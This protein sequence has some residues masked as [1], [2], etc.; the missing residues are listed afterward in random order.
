M[1]WYP[2]SGIAMSHWTFPYKSLMF[3]WIY[4]C[5]ANYSAAMVYGPW[6]E[7]FNC[8]HMATSTCIRHARHHW[9]GWL[10]WMF[11]RVEN[12]P[13]CLHCKHLSKNV[14]V[15]SIRVLYSIWVIHLQQGQSSVTILSWFK[16]GCSGR[17]VSNSL[18]GHHERLVWSSLEYVEW[19]EE[20]QAGKLGHFPSGERKAS[21]SLVPDA[22]AARGRAEPIVVLQ[23]TDLISRG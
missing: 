20:N 10:S 22:W 21:W 2:Q 6:G 12:H 14:M 13:D 23:L 7:R 8:Q 11:H 1:W 17:T 16:N 5:L 9:W 3:L 4:V 19:G 15:P 18:T